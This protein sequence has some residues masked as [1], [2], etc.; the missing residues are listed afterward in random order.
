[1][2]EREIIII[3]DDKNYIIRHLQMCLSENESGSHKIVATAGNV[4]EVD[5][6]DPNLK[7]TP[8]LA[9]VDGKM[10]L[11]GDGEKAAKILREKYKGIK[12]ISNSLAP[13]TYGDVA[14]GKHEDFNTIQRVV[15]EI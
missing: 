6:L 11:E 10:P 5:A 9:I 4:R 14:L 3:V 1:M 8:T 13:Q 7:P 12:I 15:R 2:G